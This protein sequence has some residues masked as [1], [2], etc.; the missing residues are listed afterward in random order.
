[1][2]KHW[3][4]EIS[5]L[6]ST[7]RVGIEKLKGFSTEAKY[8]KKYGGTIEP[9]E[10]FDLAEVTEYLNM[11]LLDGDQTEQLPL[12]E[13]IHKKLLLPYELVD[14]YPKYRMCYFLRDTNTKESKLILGD[15]LAPENREKISPLLRH[16]IAFI[17]GQVYEGEQELCDILKTTCYD[18]TENPVVRH[19]AILAFYDIIKD[20]ELIDKLKNHENLLIRESVICAIHMDD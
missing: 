13:R 19:E 6:K 17:L 20:Q 10:P 1:M 14:E 11:S 18:E 7:V 8:G 3:D 5:V 12:L 9:A 4:S 2:Q 16:E 15:L